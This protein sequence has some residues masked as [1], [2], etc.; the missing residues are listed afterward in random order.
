MCQAP[1]PSLTAKALVRD[2]LD[3]HLGEHGFISGNGDDTAME[4]FQE[5]LQRDVTGVDAVGIAGYVTGVD[6][7]GAAG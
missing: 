5:L 4:V 6:A 1:H 3:F 7:V 2:L